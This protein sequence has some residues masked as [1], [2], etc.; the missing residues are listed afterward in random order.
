M[1][2]CRVVIFITGFA[3]AAY[4]HA[5]RWYLTGNNLYEMCKSKNSESI[6]E[7]RFFLYGVLDGRVT[8]M[9]ERAEI[10]GRSPPLGICFPNKTASIDDLISAVVRQI[11]DDRDLYGSARA[12]FAVIKAIKKNFPCEALGNPAA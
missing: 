12:G 6:N 8:Y 5:D 4:A 10:D 1:N 3:L 2:L 9:G 11:E 7:C